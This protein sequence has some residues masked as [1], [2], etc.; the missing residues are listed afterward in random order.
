MILVQ[1]YTQKCQI[2]PKNYPY[3]IL[4]QSVKRLLDVSVRPFDRRL[5][6]RILLIL[7]VGGFLATRS[8]HL[9]RSKSFGVEGK[10]AFGDKGGEEDDRATDR[11]V[12]AV[13]RIRDQQH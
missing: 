5:L 11:K 8:W 9:D 2:Y 4:D 1:L 10:G 13:S 6:L 12:D 3:S 7:A